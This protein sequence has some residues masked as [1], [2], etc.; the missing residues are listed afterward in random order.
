M[1]GSS[2]DFIRAFVAVRPDA[3]AVAELVRVQRGLKKA[4][5]DCG[6]RIKWTEP[7]TFHSTLLFLGD[8][9]VDGAAS[10]FQT[11]ER[12][13][14]GHR[15]FSGCLREIGVFK[16]SGALWCGFEVPG[17]MDFQ[18]VL[19]AALKVEPGRFCPHMTLG[20]IKRGRPNSAFLQTLEDAAVDPVAFDI[21]AVELVRSELLP[22]GPRH[23]VLG[24]AMF[25]G[26]TGG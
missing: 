20:R 6:L 12:T 14:S 7:Q 19:A 22:D 1:S 9:P 11:L 17:L 18:Q 26:K 5:A 8:I 25:A 23:T 10:V 24:K 4:L 21:D 16:K 2:T 15:C 3:A 13:A